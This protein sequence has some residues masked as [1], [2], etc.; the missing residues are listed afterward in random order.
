MVAHLNT[1]LPDDAIVAQGAGNFTAWL[2]RFYVYRGFPTEIGPINGSMGYGLPAAIAAKLRHPG[3]TVVCLTGDGDFLMTG[4]ELATAVGEN[5][6]IVILLV[7]NGAYGTIRMHQETHYPGR[8]IA[9]KLTNPD[10]AALAT[11]L[12]RARRDGDAHGGVRRRIRSRAF[13]RQAG[14]DPAHAR[15]GRDLAVHHAD[16]FAREGAGRALI[17]L[18]DLLRV[19][20]DDRLLLGG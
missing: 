17:Q 19:V 14:A 12:W 3:R 20:A 13:R 11:R 10:F 9:T 8:V 2:R 6:A 16:G 18:E 7:N 4:Q 15:S 5:L 1:V